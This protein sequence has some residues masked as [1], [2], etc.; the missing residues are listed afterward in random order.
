M[1]RVFVGHSLACSETTAAGQATA[2]ARQACRD[3]CDTIIAAG[4][5]GTVN[6]VANGII[7]SDVALGVIPTGTANDLAR[8]H[9]IPTDPEAACRVILQNRQRYLDAICV[10][11][12]HYLTVGGF[13]LPCGAVKEAETI[14]HRGVASRMFARLLGSKLYL[15]ALAITYRRSTR[16]AISMRVNSAQSA[17]RGAA[18]SV[19]VANQ[20]F[21]GRNFLVSPEAANDDGRL[22]L[23]AITDCHSRRLL[24]QTVLST[25]T[26]GKE[27]PESVLR[28]QSTKLMIE[29]THQ[30]P[31]FGD[32]E[33][34]G[35]SSSFD[36]QV[37]PAAIKL[38]VPEER[39]VPR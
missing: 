33:L 30:L 1:N 4:G 26:G 35:E 38:I 31:F 5:D 25:V 14:K 15:L 39:A 27:Q 8:Y 11:G 23:F 2:I 9:G 7:G 17:W 28:L 32:G 19:I 16:Q 10:N 13:G 36:F 21:L 3:S 18:Y 24:L 12:W 37:I 22:D 34:H 6:E 29:A 20:P